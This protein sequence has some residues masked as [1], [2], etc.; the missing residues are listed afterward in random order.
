MNDQP[1]NTIPDLPEP[2]GCVTHSITLKG[3]ELIASLLSGDKDVENRIFAMQG[4]WHCLHL[5]KSTPSAAMKSYMQSL[6]PGL[7]T[8]GFRPGFI[9]GMVFVSKSLPLQ[10]YRDSV[11]CYACDFTTEIPTHL[12]HCKAN[13][14]VMGIVLN[15]V[16][17]RVRFYRP[18]AASGSLGRWPLSAKVKA[19][20]DQQ[21]RNGSYTLEVANGDL[22]KPHSPEVHLKRRKLPSSFDIAEAVRI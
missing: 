10:Q 7:N 9:Y 20:I 17:H 3:A 18:V 2:L 11:G 1:R 21:I 8:N 14:H 5:G 16:S 6:C 13:R 22:P 12:P 4:K 19:E 15:V